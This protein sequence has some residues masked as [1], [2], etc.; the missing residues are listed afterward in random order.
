M[1]TKTF[2]RKKGP[3]IFRQKEHAF[4][5]YDPEIR[6]SYE[7]D[8]IWSIQIQACLE[9]NEARAI[10][11]LGIFPKIQLPE[12]DENQYVYLCVYLH[13][14]KELLSQLSYLLGEQRFINPIEAIVYFNSSTF[15]FY[16]V[17][18]LYHL[19]KWKVFTH[20]IN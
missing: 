4:F 12:Y 20:K 9:E 2:I 17:L 14:K 15:P 3:L 5:V 19:L 10:C 16:R 11:D 6:V 8:T 7:M 18:S 13:G 1:E